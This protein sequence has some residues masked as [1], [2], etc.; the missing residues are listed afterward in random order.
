[1]V[2]DGMERGRG[3][4]DI[5]YCNSYVVMCKLKLVRVF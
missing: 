3:V 4:Y 2:W 1:M 5:V